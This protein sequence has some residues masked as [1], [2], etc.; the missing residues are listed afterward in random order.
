MDETS[1]IRT[2]M[3]FRAQGTLFCVLWSQCLG[4]NRTASPLFRRLFARVADNPT[5]IEINDGGNDSR[6]KDASDDDVEYGSDSWS[7]WE[8]EDDEEGE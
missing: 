7:G 6:W 4:L 8:S 1:V 3:R 2:C 5:D